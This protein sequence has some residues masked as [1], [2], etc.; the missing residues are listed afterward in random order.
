[1][2]K[3]IFTISLDFELHWGG[4]EKWP[5]NDG[6]KEYFLNTRKCI[7][8]LLSLFRQRDIHVTWATVGLLMHKRKEELIA[9]LPEVQPAYDMPQ[10]SAYNYIEQHAIGE[11]EKQDPF[12]FAG[13]LMEEIIKVP[14]QEIGTH[15]FSHYY[16]KEPG[17]N[18]GQ[19]TADLKAA[20]AVASNYGIKP[21]SLIFPRNQFNSEYLEVCAAEGIKIAR[22]NPL[23]WWWQIDS[24]QKESL[25]KRFNRG[26]DAYFAIG[27]KT[28][29]PL[30]SIKKE[31]GVIL[32][33]ASRLLRPFNPKELFLNQQK[34]KKIKKEMTEAARN[35]EVYHLW[36]HPHNFGT[37]TK[38]NMQG[39]IEIANHFQ[40]LK[41][42][43]GMVSLNMGEIADEMGNR[44]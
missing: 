2:E 18:S 10:L 12:H 27:G 16:C 28:S 39:L 44:E 35:K 42:E 15:T 9:Q 41:Q 17:Q 30:Q 33:P 25:W 29:F 43:F 8:K 5:L 36:W 1:M 14:G 31:N 40:K 3:G 13:S 32:L 19:F 34:I 6:Y 11:D 7:P 26:L 22:I 23:D 20:A 37:H 24:T 4:F 38:Q 21:V